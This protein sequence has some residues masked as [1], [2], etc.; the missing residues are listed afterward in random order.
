MIEKVVELEAFEGPRLLV[1]GRLQ[2]FSCFALRWEC[3]YWL[4]HGNEQEQEQLGIG[5]KQTDSAY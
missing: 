5:A 1:S 3:P 2:N 4:L